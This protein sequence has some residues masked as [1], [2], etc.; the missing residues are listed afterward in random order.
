MEAH[1]G[2]QKSHRRTHTCP[3]GGGSP[4]PQLPEPPGPRARM[5]R[6]N[7]RECRPPAVPTCS[8]IPVLPAAWYPGQ[9]RVFPEE[10]L[11]SAS[12]DSCT[13]VLL[14]RSETRQLRNR[15][16]GRPI[17]RLTSRGSLAPDSSAAAALSCRGFRRS[18]MLLGRSQRSRRRLPDSTSRERSRASARLLGRCSQGTPVLGGGGFFPVA[19]PM[20]SNPLNLH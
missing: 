20:F 14:A 8:T 19:S 9:Q 1:S 18:R 2:A 11:V 4:G 10:H 3:G 15:G 16:E 13:R 6:Q 17:P 12:Q 5:L 7:Q